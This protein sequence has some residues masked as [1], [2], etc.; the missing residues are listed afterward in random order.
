MVEL[1]SMAQYAR[2]RGVS[3][4]AVSKAVAARRITLIEGRIDPTVADIQ[5]AVNT[6]PRRGGRAPALPDRAP[7]GDEAGCED[8]EQ[9]LGPRRRR[10]TALAELAEL[11]LAHKRAALVSAVELDC[12]LAAKLAQLDQVLDALAVRIAPLLAAQGD[13]PGVYAVLRAEIRQALQ[14]LAGPVAG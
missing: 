12:A 10:E 5:W 6:A 14:Q 13:A 11:E 7:A 2:Y 9:L 3:R 8:L 1:M 4:T